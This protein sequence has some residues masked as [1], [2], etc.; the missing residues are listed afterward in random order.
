[1]RPLFRDLAR[2]MVLLMIGLKGNLFAS[3]ARILR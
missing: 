2:S 3:V 1:M